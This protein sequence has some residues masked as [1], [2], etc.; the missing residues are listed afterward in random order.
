V[1]CGVWGVGCGVWGVGCSLKGFMG[2][3]FVLGGLE[4]GGEDFGVWG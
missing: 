4:F 2:S 1:G 3:A